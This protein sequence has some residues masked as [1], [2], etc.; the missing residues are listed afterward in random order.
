[1]PGPDDHSAAAVDVPV[2]TKL[3]AP[4]VRAEWV[5]RCGLVHDLDDAQVK[6]VLVEAPAGYGK[7]TLLAQW[8][9]Q[10]GPSRPFAWISLDPGDDDPVRLWEHIVSALRRARPGLGAE[11]I[12]RQLRRQIPDVDAALVSLINELTALAAPV[13]I[14]L[15][16]YHVIKEPR[17]HEQLEYLLLRLPPEVKVVLG[18]RADPPLSLGRL[19]AAGE[20]AEVR[21]PDLQF[22]AD[23]A[24]A[25]IRQVASVKLDEQDLSDLLEQTEGWPAGVYLAALSL[26][27]HPAPNDFV[28][29]F[30]GGNRYIVDFLAEEITSRQPEPIQ[31]FLLRTAVLGRFTAALCD[32]VAGTTN[33][34]EIIGKLERENLFLVS[35]DS[36]REWYR[37]HHLFAQLLLGQLAR[38]EPGTIP[39]LHRRASAWHLERGSA[40]EAIGHA[41]AAGDAA[42]SVTLIARHWHRYVLAG[43]TAT[44]LRWLR[45]LGDEHV[46]ASPLAAHCAAWT[47]A[48]AGD[49]GPARRLLPVIAAGGDEGP[50]PDGMRSLRSSAALLEGTY[51]FTGLEPMREAGARAVELE[52]DPR[53][54]WY[55]LARIS[56]AGCLYLCGEFGAATRQLEQA[57]LASPSFPLVRLWYLALIAMVAVEQGRLD[58]AEQMAYSARDIVT[59]E[60]L[61]MSEA[62]QASEVYLALGTVLAAR[63]RF[64]EAREHYERAL[65]SRRKLFADSA[66][67]TIDLMLKLAGVL[68]ELGDRPAAAALLGE[69]RE[70][71]TSFPDGAGVQLHRLERLQRRLTGAQLTGKRGSVAA[72]TSSLTAAEVRLLPL[73]R[74]HLTFPEIGAELFLSPNTVKSQVYS[75]YR[76]LGVSTRNQAISRV[77][78]LGLLEE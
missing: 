52:N 19:R 48:L 14:I 20:M 4:R 17:C 76:K 5:E 63:G 54:I 77:L 26:R 44:V 49:L 28:R 72:G 33:A 75:L 22:T 9:A 24:D 15:D 16:D 6:L 27:G 65:R 62:P 35:L 31:Q 18:T 34:R 71:L 46:T 57:L 47:W 37:Y 60:T 78:E 67:P 61:G 41:L 40:D 1:M 53:L 55:A 64:S 30:S 42:G 23:E 10:A 12:L 21:V 74:T 59:D 51:G 8:C 11:K 45:S 70:A 7:T 68:T 43:R 3:H 58:Q 38:A 39:A 69:A 25:I 66:W 73:L 2:E 56:Y 13:V 32:A 29:S 36:N 50:L